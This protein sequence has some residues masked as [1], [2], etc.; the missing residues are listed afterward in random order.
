MEFPSG[1]STAVILRRMMAVDG[2]ADFDVTLDLRAGF[3]RSQMRD[4]QVD[5]GIWTARSGRLRIRWSGADEAHLRSDGRLQ[6]RKH[7]E[8][9]D[10]HDLVLEISDKALPKDPPDPDASWRKTENAWAEAV[11]QFNDLMARRDARQSY[12]VLRGMTS[13]GGGMVAAATLGLPERAEA[14]RN[15]DYRYAWIRDQCFTGQAAATTGAHPLLDDAVSFVSQRVL[16][17]GP[18]LS[19]AYRVDGGEVPDER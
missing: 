8:E 12:A 13:A 6:L 11:P 19:P 1:P 9:G 7:I 2:P 17:D 10:S 4:V 15:Y 5:H 16:S 14:G 3:G 18:K